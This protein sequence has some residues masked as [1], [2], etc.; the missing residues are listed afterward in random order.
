M[1]YSDLKRG[2]KS[3][4]LGSNNFCFS[5]VV[6][7]LSFFIFYF[8]SP[9][10]T[11]LTFWFFGS[12]DVWNFG[13]FRG[14][15]RRLGLLG[16]GP[17]WL[18]VLWQPDGRRAAEHLRRGKLRDGVGPH[19]REGRDLV[20]QG[21]G[22]RVQGSG[23]SSE[24]PRL[25]PFRPPTHSPGPFSPGCPLWP[26]ATRRFQLAVNWR[27][28]GRWRGS[29]GRRTEETSSPDTTTRCALLAVLRPPC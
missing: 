8:F 22:F 3:I 23:V 16:S 24:H 13:R 9:S 17:H 10:P 25:T 28:W 5:F 1:S 11:P 21:S 26:S 18:E 15:H 27:G 29:T 7:P 14:F 20:G 6:L 12:S 4:S 2:V 19:P